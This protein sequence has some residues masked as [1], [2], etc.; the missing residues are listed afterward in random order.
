MILFGV[1]TA[2]Y[3]KDGPVDPPEDKPVL[4][5]EEDLLAKGYVQTSRWTLSEAN[6]ALFELT[7]LQIEVSGPNSQWG[8]TTPSFLLSF[9]TDEGNSWQDTVL[10]YKKPPVLLGSYAFYYKEN[11]IINNK[12]MGTIAVYEKP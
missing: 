10:V 9:S 11:K 4:T 8:T 1:L 6:R 5:I 7:D 2:C 12:D 3:Q